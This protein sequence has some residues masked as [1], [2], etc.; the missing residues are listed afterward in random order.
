MSYND[1]QIQPAKIVE[2]TKKPSENYRAWQ[3]GRETRNT[4]VGWLG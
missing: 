4:I 3:F 2:K 1:R